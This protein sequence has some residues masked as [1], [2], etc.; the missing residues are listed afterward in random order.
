M[1]K[2]NSYRDYH[3]VTSPTPAPRDAD[4]LLLLWSGISARR[5][6]AD[7]LIDLS[8]CVLSSAPDF[9]ERDELERTL[10]K[11]LSLLRDST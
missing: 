7:H 1:A 8:L 9:P 11:A 2:N 10:R 6:E 5:N 3:F 4:I